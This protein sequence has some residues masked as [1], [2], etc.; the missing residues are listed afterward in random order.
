M[1]CAAVIAVGV[2]R[3][4]ALIRMVPN[5]H[6]HAFFLSLFSFSC[7]FSCSSHFLPPPL[8]F[9]PLTGLPEVYSTLPLTHPNLLATL[10]PNYCL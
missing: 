2:G 5:T 6:M 4:P 7:L 8:H 9:S 10:L 3:D 1:F